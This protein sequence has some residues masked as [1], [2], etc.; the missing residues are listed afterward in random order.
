[1]TLVPCQWK[2]VKFFDLD[3]KL[4]VQG[5]AP[6]VQLNKKHGINHLL[7]LSFSSLISLDA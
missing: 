6:R 7:F 2:F 3:M 5:Q 4:S 1:M